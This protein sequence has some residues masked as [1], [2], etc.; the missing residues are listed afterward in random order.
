[1]GAL[2]RA[3]AGLSAR[4][5]GISYG[6][7]IASELLLGGLVAK[8][9]AGRFVGHVSQLRLEAILILVSYYLG[10]F[11][12]GFASPRV[13]VAEPAIGAALSVA[14]TFVIAFFSPLGFLSFKAARVLAG[15]VIAFLLALAG[16]R[17]GEKAAALLGNDAS[18]DYADGS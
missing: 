3:E 5:I 4:W 15:G 8:V 7:F 6:V 1:M 9:I 17:T 2:T 18:R 14:T 13:R 12:V 10:G 16:A 11:L